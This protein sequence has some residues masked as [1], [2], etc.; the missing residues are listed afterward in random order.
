MIGDDEP[1]DP[2][3]QDPETQDRARALF[4]ALNDRPGGARE[5]EALAWRRAHPA[6]EAAWL[7]AE[8]A[9][10]SAG[11]LSQLAEARASHLA[12]YLERIEAHQ[13]TRRRCKKKAAA[14]GITAAVLAA[15]LW[16]NAPHMFQ[17]LGADH[18]A[19]AAHTLSVA[20]GDGSTVLLDAD[21]ALSE[22][23][24]AGQRH[25]RLLR[26]GAYFEVK[27]DTRPF[28]VETPDGDIRVLGTGFDVQILEGAAQVTLA[29]G[30]V[31]VSARDASTVLAPGQT[32]RLHAG[33][34]GAVKETNLE[35]A[36]AWRDGC[37]AFYDARLGDVVAQIQRYRK[38][39]I[40]IATRRLADERVSGS[41]ALAD[42]DA[43]LNSLRA[44]F[45][46]RILDLGRL[47]VIS[48]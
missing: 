9:W 10:Q 4:L 20:L 41:F 32:V 1:D 43:A 7:R 3:K 45:G 48:P 19:P 18:V 25:V 35:T 24:I 30:R 6:H 44:S 34:V 15:G 33:G 47:I 23:N 14:G 8:A 38:G 31:E 22:Q 36:L 28:V 2:E 13:T 21:S 27:A 40:I 37:Y 26:G 5:A 17:N 29:H 12:G 16:L 11:T 42:A 46:F 39:R